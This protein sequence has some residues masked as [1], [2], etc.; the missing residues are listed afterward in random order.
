MN[1]DK[2][3]QCHVN[4]LPRN[5]NLGGA[6][7]LS[8][9][10]PSYRAAC[11]TVK[12]ITGCV[13]QFTGDAYVNQICAE[14][15]KAM[16]D[17]D[18]EVAFYELQRLRGWYDDNLRAIANNRA[19]YNKNAH[20]RA[21]QQI[22]TVYNTLEEHPEWF[23]ERRNELS[24]ESEPTVQKKRMVFIS[25]SSMDVEYVTAFV[26]L[27]EA[28]KLDDKNLFCSSRPGLGIPAGEDVFD[29]LKHCFTDYELCVIL[30]LSRDNYYS[31][32][33]CLNEMGAAW[34]QGAKCYS[35]LLPGM[36]SEMMQGAIGS[37][38]IAVKLD[39]DE[40]RYR[41]T[42]VKDGIVS[43]LGIEEPNQNL[44]MSKCDTFL[45]QVRAISEKAA[46]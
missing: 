21:Y 11:S 20:L 40:A 44:W 6:T 3:G 16:L 8:L 25:H 14:L 29:F 28:L 36:R 46:V 30:L 42:E 22:P 41:L 27:L 34:V 4:S 10:I 18:A 5:H 12:S 2:R 24:S 31:S 7:S 35:V 33:A 17:G 43:F 39:S 38:S 1:A 23:E 9:E 45:V 32:A 19:V 13:R 15:E 37:R 26:D